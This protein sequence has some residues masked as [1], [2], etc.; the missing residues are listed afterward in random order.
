MYAVVEF[1]SGKSV[2]LDGIKIG[3]KTGTSEKPI[4]G[5]Y[6]K[7]LF[8]ATF[9]AVAPIENPKLAIY[10]FVDEPKGAT[11]GSEVAAPIAKDILSSVVP[12]MGLYEE[13][14]NSNGKVEVEVPNLIGLSYN[15]GGKLLKSIGLTI[16]CFTIWSRR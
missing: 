12:Y 7:N 15:A 14:E 10:V 3:G 1:G 2:K 5:K 8:I 6:S 9:V 11:H 4:N 13:A 16:Y